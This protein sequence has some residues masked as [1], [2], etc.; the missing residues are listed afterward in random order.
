MNQDLT[1]ESLLAMIQKT[2]QEKMDAGFGFPGYPGELYVS[3]GDRLVR[4]AVQTDEKLTPA[5][6]KRKNL[7]FRKTMRDGAPWLEMEISIT[8]NLPEVVAT[9]VAV[10]NRA[11]EKPETPVEAIGDVLRNMSLLLSQGRGLSQQQEVGLIGEIVALSSFA[12]EFGAEQALQ[13]WRGVEGSDQDFL[14]GESGFE[15]K[16][17]T[18][19]QRHHW[20]SSK[21]QLE[22][23]PAQALY[24]YSV[25]I[26][27]GSE[28]GLTLPQ[29]L[30]QAAERLGV[31]E[32]LMNSKAVEIGYD[33]EDEAFYMNKWHLR[34]MPLLFDVDASFPA[35]T[36]A[37]LSQ[38]LDE[39]ER[40]LDFQYQVSLEGLPPSKW[41]LP[42]P[43]LGV[44]KH[45]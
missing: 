32:Q 45:A 14:I 7:F 25:M 3:S 40:L 33:P 38:T 37:S 15:I 31:D 1:P 35:I 2:F 12:L 24:V 39:P 44:L 29:F 30:I 36:P 4:Y 22:P 5:V 11:R 19:S 28:A 17:T 23:A 20:M 41:Q 43:T 10:F 9:V 27:S 18:S 13:G 6:S 34:S 26:Q 21:M 16:T 42:T 8:N